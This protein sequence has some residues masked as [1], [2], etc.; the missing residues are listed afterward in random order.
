M[1]MY[2]ALYIH[3]FLFS[4]GFHGKMQH[5]CRKCKLPVRDVRQL[6]LSEAFGNE[7]K[8]SLLS[9]EERESAVNIAWDKEKTF[10]FLGAV[11]E[12]A[13]EPFR[14]ATLN[15]RNN[16]E[17][18]EILISAYLNQLGKIPLSK[19][20]FAERHVM[21]IVKVAFEAGGF[22][23]V[24]GV[25]DYVAK[26]FLGNIFDVCDDVARRSC[27][28]LL[29]SMNGAWKDD[30]QLAMAMTT[31]EN[32]RYMYNA[33]IMENYSSKNVDK[34]LMD[35]L[36][37]K[38]TKVRDKISQTYAQVVNSLELSKLVSDKCTRNRN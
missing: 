15:M 27:D 21:P 29:M 31:E 30:E 16:A 4:E 18:L 25:F 7:E 1:E 3:F 32:M 8:Q 28:D 9:N 37:T 5:C 19:M 6:L 10:K 33:F 13:T 17:I 2:F 14:E 20:E 38:F 11:G 36:S 12:S 24:G 26:C 35:I 22:G 23:F 34:T